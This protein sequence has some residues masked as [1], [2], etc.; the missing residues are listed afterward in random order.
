MW[1]C[2]NSLKQEFTYVAIQRNIRAVNIRGCAKVDGSNP[3]L[4]GRMRVLCTFSSAG[5]GK[6]GEEVNLVNLI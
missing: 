6:R 5:L 4:T 2:F 3:L 1:D